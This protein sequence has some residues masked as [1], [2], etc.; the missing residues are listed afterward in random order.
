VTTAAASEPSRYRG[1]SAIGEDLRRFWSLTF[2]LAA[3]DF[4][5]RFFGSALGY[6]WSLI[7]PLLLFG[8]LYVVFTEIIRFGAGVPHYPVYLLESLVLFTFFSETTSRG[9]TSLVDRENLLR[10]IRFPRLVIPLSVSLHALFNLTLNLIVVF[11]FVLASG[12]GPR[13]EWLELPVLLVFLVVFST[14]VTM[15]LSALF[16]RFRDIEPIWEVG[17]QLLFYGSP[18]LYV[19]TTVPESV[20]ELAAMNPIAVVLTQMRH[21]II[22]PD[23]PTAAAAVGGWEWLLVPVAIVAA[24]FAIGFWTFARE[25]PRIAENL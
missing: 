8:V 21:A 9:L 24:V 15:L 6:L 16:V 19:I 11:V 25:T 18:V 13:L 20:R 22:D 1:P 14:G 10:K 7:R 4:K 17:L 3:T 5:L 23:A 2:T 12:I